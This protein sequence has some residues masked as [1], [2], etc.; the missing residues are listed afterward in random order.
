MLPVREFST[1]GEMV[2]HYAALRRRLF[3]PCPKPPALARLVIAPPP[4][5]PVEE[6]LSA[7]FDSITRSLLAQVKACPEA[8][9]VL[10]GISHMT[11]AKIRAIQEEIAEQ[12]GITRADIIGPSRNSKHVA[13]RQFAIWRVKQETP[14][15]LPAIGRHFGGRDH[16]T[17]LHSIRKVERIMREEATR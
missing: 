16:T 7:D 11:P 10:D 1:A 3:N 9:Q 14:L 15:S 17:A 5:K 8:G 6:Q 4:P 12:F 13:A 2:A